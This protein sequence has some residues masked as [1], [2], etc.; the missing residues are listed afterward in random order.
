MPKLPRLQATAVSTLSLCHHPLLFLQFSP[1]PEAAS[2]VS[3]HRPHS[4]KPPPRNNGLPLPAALLAT[5]PMALWAVQP[6]LRPLYRARPPC[7]LVAGAL[8]PPPKGRG[9]GA[10]PTRRQGGGR[11]Q[12]DGSRV[13]PQS[14]LRTAQR[15]HRPFQPSSPR[16]PI[17]PRRMEATLAMELTVAPLPTATAIRTLRQILRLQVLEQH[18]QREQRPQACAARNRRAPRPA[19]RLLRP[20]SSPCFVPDPVK[21][22]VTAA[23]PSP[24]RQSACEVHYNCRDP[25]RLPQAVP[26]PHLRRRTPMPPRLQPAGPHPARGCCRGRPSSCHSPR[27]SPQSYACKKPRPPWSCKVRP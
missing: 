9:T 8:R 3:Q 19:P 21:P 2:C 13:A 17:A 1:R 24:T 20:R 27:P 15:C 25:K 4:N 14:C 22:R 5:T 10:W 6:R 11:P 18:C 26:R 16:T 7:G 12:A 23:S